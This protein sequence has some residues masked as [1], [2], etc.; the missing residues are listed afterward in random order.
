VRKRVAWVSRHTPLPAQISELKRLGYSDDIVVISKTF[1]SV[2]DVMAE[3]TAANATAAVVV[4]PLGMIA[5]LLPL[6]RRE[7][8]TLLWAE[9][10]PPEPH[11]GPADKCLGPKECEA[12]NPS[13][14]VWL[15]LSGQPHGRHLRFKRFHEI[16]EVKL[17]TRPL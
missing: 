5:E 7:G 6:A 10:A 9:M 16:L 11:P 1:A 14:D 13:S 3:I 8:V 12:F 2:N 15:P 4:L 17:V